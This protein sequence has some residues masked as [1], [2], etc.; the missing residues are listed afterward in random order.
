MPLMREL[1]RLT[2]SVLQYPR[3]I[4]VGADLTQCSL[5]QALQGTGFDLAK[6]AVFLCEGLLYYLPQ[7]RV[8]S[9]AAVCLQM[10][11]APH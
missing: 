10:P 6:P 4:F 8:M 5:Q 9:H 7:V 3:P 11:G 1:C 2:D